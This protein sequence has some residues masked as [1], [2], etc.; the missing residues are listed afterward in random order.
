MSLVALAL[1]GILPALDI[2]GLAVGNADPQQNQLLITLFFLG[3]G[4]GPLFFGPLSDTL[5]RKP[6][7][8]MGFA[9]FIAASMLCVFAPNLELMI[10]GRIL[11]GAA[12][13]A[14]RTISIAMIRDLFSGDYMA[15]IMSFVTVVFILVPTIAPALGKLLLDSL[16]WH[17]IFYAQLGIGLLVCFWFWK[18][19]KETL[20]PE[21]RK[22]FKHAVFMNGCRE[23]F[24]SKKTMV[25][26]VIWGLITGGFLVYLS[27]AQQVFQEQFMLKEAFPYIFAGLALTVG[28]SSLVNGSLVLRF[29][30]LKLVTYALISFVCLALCYV[31]CF[32]GQEN[33]P[34]VVALVFLALQFLSVGFLF[35]NIRS[36]AMEPLGHIAGIGAAITGCLAT[37]IGVPISTFIGRYVTTTVWPMFMGFL[38]CGVIALLLIGYYRRGN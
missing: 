17:A 23:V 24:R 14:P 36:L 13:S 19:Q 37:L 6:V 31:C 5:G 38:V 16:G 26:T 35:G 12:L 11:Q 10:L 29:G 20:V 21:N 2:I 3:L 25:F 28:F 27:T 1:D 7:V 34:F 9:L 32:I 30:T 15:R 22:P 4:T 18:R 33:P 8:Y